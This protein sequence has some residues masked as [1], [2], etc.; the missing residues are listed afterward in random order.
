[1]QCC[2]SLADNSNSHFLYS[3][4][5]F[6][7]ENCRLKGKNIDFSWPRDQT[8]SEHS[9]E[10]DLFLQVS[11]VTHLQQLDIEYVVHSRMGLSY[12]AD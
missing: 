8:T 1:M 4:C 6:R 11:C 7:L 5:S 10:S 2:E 12:K 9:S 3:L